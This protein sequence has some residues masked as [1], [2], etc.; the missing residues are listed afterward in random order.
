[1]VP[2]GREAGRFKRG[3]DL[4]ADGSC[5]RRR[6]VEAAVQERESVAGYRGI[7]AL[8]MEIDKAAGVGLGFATDQS[9]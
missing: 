7:G 2:F 4:A 1:M 3:H 6:A 9:R 5:G 8:G